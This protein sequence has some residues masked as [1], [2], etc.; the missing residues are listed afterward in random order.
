MFNKLVFLIKKI[1]ISMFIIY[2]Y[3]SLA[4]SFNMI[5]PINISTVT[6]V[7]IFGVIA[8]FELIIFFFF[9]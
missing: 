3:N 8:M 1:I 6:L 9:F 4:I 5:I 2:A 7:S